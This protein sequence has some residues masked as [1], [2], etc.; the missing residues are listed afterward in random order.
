MILMSDSHSYTC[1]VLL[2][3]N[4]MMNNGFGGW[5]VW[6][7]NLDDFSGEFCNEGRYPLISFLSDAVAGHATP[8]P[9][10]AGPTTSSHIHP[11]SPSSTTTH[12]PNPAPTDPPT[13][14]TY[15]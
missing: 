11:T 10:T 2:Q 14:E 5:M 12:P 9:P 1:N 7:M 13:G 3:V 15:K 6:D 4:W 8:S